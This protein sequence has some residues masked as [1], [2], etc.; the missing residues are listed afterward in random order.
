MTNNYSTKKAALIGAAFFVLLFQKN[1]YTKISY[2]EVKLRIMTKY[3]KKNIIIN[4]SGL[5]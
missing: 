2:S 1:Y 5:L 3:S 4:S